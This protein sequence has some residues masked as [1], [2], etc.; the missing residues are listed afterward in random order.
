[1]NGYKG[2]ITGSGVQRVQAPVRTGKTK[3]GHAVQGE[4]LRTGRPAAG[5]KPEKPGK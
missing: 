3:G 1:M 5:G 2:K 4:D